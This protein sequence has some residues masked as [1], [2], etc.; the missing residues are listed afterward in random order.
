MDQYN[1]YYIIFNSAS[2]YNNNILSYDYINPVVQFLH[3][4]SVIHF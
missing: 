2:S 4:I 3:F 1:I